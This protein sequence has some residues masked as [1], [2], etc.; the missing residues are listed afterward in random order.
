MQAAILEANGAPFTLT[1]IALPQPGPGQVRVR[2][3]ASGVNPLDL[4]IHQGQA[5]HA[6]HPVPA[7]LGL[8]LAGTVEAVGEGVTAF[9][10]A[11]RSM[12]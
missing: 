2:I 3:A 8:D 7:V 12:A 5:A 4:K 6:K 1:T 11:M 9:A 10:P